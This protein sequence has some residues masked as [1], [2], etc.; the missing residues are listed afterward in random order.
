[1]NCGKEMLSTHTRCGPAGRRPFV[2]HMTIV[3]RIKCVLV[4]ERKEHC[5]ACKTVRTVNEFSRSITKGY[6]SNLFD[7][8]QLLANYKTE[9]RRWTGAGSLYWAVFACA[10]LQVQPNQADN[11]LSCLF[12]ETISY[13]DRINHTR[14]QYECFH[15]NFNCLLPMETD[16]VVILCDISLP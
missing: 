5:R 8:L 13:A 12:D 15:I 4:P 6:I 10:E 14:V 1:M 11:L 16:I 9:I 7:Y 3:R 2:W